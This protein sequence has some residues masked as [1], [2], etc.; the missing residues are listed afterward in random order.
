[1]KDR[2]S[3]TSHPLEIN[4]KGTEK[5]QKQSKI[6]RLPMGPSINEVKSVLM[7]QPHFPYCTHMP[8]LGVKPTLWLLRIM[9]T[10]TQSLCL[11]RTL[12]SP[13]LLHWN[14]WVTNSQHVITS[15]LMK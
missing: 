13:L 11:I 1:L 3:I 2:R 9:K 15:T 14:Y 4:H 12:L 7:S 8:V 10:S 5:S 6:C